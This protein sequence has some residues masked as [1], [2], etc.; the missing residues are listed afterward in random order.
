MQKLQPT[1]PCSTI[2]FFIEWTIVSRGRGGLLRWRK[3]LDLHECTLGVSIGDKLRNTVYHIDRLPM[4]VARE[5]AQQV[6]RRE[7]LTVKIERY[8]RAAIP[9]TVATSGGAPLRDCGRS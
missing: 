7:Y 4:D 6:S 1:C 8:L 9:P 2:A 3:K 5:D